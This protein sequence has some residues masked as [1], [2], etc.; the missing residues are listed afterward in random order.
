MV[1]RERPVTAAVTRLLEALTLDDLGQARAA[2][3]VALAQRIDDT[4]SATTG[5][6]AMA[7]AGL[8]RELQTTL[9]A[10]VAPSEA[11]SADAFLHRLIST[12]PT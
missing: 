4:S 1:T 10:I 8:S 11:E 9:E 7:A 3:A 2:V 6:A 12:E 5:A